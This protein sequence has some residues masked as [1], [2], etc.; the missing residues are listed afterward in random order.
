MYF[1]IELFL[2]RM[3]SY[4]SSTLLIPTFFFSQ[5]GSANIFQYGSYL[6]YKNFMLGG[7]IRHNSAFRFIT[8]IFQVGMSYDDFK[9]SY[10]Y[11][12]GFLDY[13]KISVFSGAHE[14]TLSLNFS[15]KGV[16]KQ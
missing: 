14:V 16:N 10:S 4:Q 13:K 7:F 11:D 15:I 9:I 2:N 1:D 5:Q 12:A 8:P 3:D 6:K